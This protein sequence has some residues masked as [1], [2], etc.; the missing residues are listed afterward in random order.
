M[1]NFAFFRQ[2]GWVLFAT[3]AGGACNTLVHTFAR[4]MPPAE[5]GL[6]SSFLQAALPQLSIPAIGLQMFF[7]QMAAEAVSDSK[8]RD[9]A[10]AVRRVSL[11]LV[12]IWIVAAVLVFVFRESLIQ[13]YKIG[14]P[15]ALLVLMAVVLV[16][17]LNPVFSGV[18]QGRQDF[19]WF[20]WVTIVGSA[21]RLVCVALLIW[22][23]GGKSL[24]AMCG[25]LGGVAI[26]LGI[27][28]W[29]T[30]DV[31]SIESG[32]FSGR[33]FLKRVGPLT[34]GLGASTV[35]FTQDSFAAREFLTAHDSGLY[36]AAGAI[37]RA[38]VYLTGA[39]TVV[40]FPKIAREAALSTNSGVLAMAVGAT[41]LVGAVAAIFS[42]L[43]PEL[44][45]RLIHGS[46]YVQAAGL[47]T[48]FSWC[49]LPL[50]LAN[51]LLNSL[52]ARSRFGVV[53]PLALVAGIYWLAQ[54][55]FASASGK[56]GIWGGTATAT[57][58]VIIQ[59]MGVAAL[60]AFAITAAYTWWLGKAKESP[61]ASK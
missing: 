16:T 23:L 30:R 26:S 22:L 40:M 47:V 45:I 9:L 8:R 51:T 25:V 29:K 13:T 57:P 38:L 15:A 2:I 3:L 21:G 19:L 10:A 1:I 41:L 44:P 52:L 59:T 32:Y 55:R 61:P 24:W 60:A 56:P 39:V 34:L 18:L 33:D 46:D 48:W 27:A 12:V 5:Y 50:T 37:G 14:S 17:I 11:G 43:F 20:G 49:L 6:F 31:L 4:T 58:E 7:A 28:V 42:S 53:V 54:G 36:N 35:I